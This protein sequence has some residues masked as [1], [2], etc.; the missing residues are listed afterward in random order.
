M[1]S[2]LQVVLEGREA[3]LLYSPFLFSGVC[4]PFYIGYLRGAVE[5]SWWKAS[6][7]QRARGWVYF[8]VGITV[9]ITMATVTILRESTLSFFAYYIGLFSG[10]WISYMIIRW[11]TRTMD[12]R[13][14]D[15]D[16][17][18]IRCTCVAAFLLTASCYFFEQLVSLDLYPNVNSKPPY[19]SEAYFPF[20]LLLAF[21]VTEK[22][23][24]A[25]L[26]PDANFNWLI[27]KYR[28]RRTAEK[29]MAYALYVFAAGLA[30][31][32]VAFWATVISLGAL[33]FYLFQ[34]GSSQSYV[35]QVVGLLATLLLYTATFLYLRVSTERIR[36]GIPRTSER[37]VDLLKGVF[38]VDR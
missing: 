5:R 17:F 37:F 26:A 27:G 16:L 13:I 38:R 11:V 34:S 32:R 35:V 14:P 29:T 30:M 19:V 24:L 20:L 2:V 15:Q 1:F 31:N 33:F 23:C 12:A 4:Y 22:V 3:F 6:I 25:L 10:L 18:V 8:G 28:S 21:V 7:L 36:S 9:Y